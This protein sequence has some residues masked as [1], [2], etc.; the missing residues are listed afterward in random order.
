MDP[1]ARQSGRGEQLGPGPQLWNFFWNFVEGKLGWNFWNYVEAFH[2][3]QRLTIEFWPKSTL[4]F[5]ILMNLGSLT[6]IGTLKPK[7]FC[8]DSV[9]FT[10]KRII[11]VLQIHHCD[12]FGLLDMDRARI[13]KSQASQY[14]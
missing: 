8:A 9:N 10:E 11:L 6:T 7:R 12:Q 3:S 14:L 13:Q 2:P 4:K 5:D 1:C